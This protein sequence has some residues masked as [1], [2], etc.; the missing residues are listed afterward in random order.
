MS[1]RFKKIVSDLTGREV[2]AFMSQTHVGPD[3]AVEIFQ[4]GS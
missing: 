4:L 1:Q 2:I 3:L